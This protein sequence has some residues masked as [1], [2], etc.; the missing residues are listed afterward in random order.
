MEYLIKFSAIITLFYLC[1]RL[2]LYRE[3]FFEA[4][5]WFLLIGLMSATLLPYLTITTYAEQ[6]PPS[7]VILEISTTATILPIKKSINWFLILNT[8]YFLGVFFFTIRHLLQIISLIKILSHNKIHKKE[9]YKYV[10]TSDSHT[11]LF[12]FLNGLFTIPLN[13]TKQN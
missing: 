4:N 6:L 5:R 8:T 13:L 2:L 1:Y 7:L 9:E 3:T 11:P 10:V 12:R